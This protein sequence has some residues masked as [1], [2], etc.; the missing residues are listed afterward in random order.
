MQT[1]KNEF[2]KFLRQLNI[3]REIA[4]FPENI[5]RELCEVKRFLEVNIPVKMDNGEVKI[6]KGYRSQYND[7]RG[8]FKGGIRF[9]ENV[10]ESEVKALSAWM[11]F[12]CAVVD[13]PLGG[14]KGG[15]IVDPKKLSGGELERLSRGYIRAISPIIGDRVDIPAPD[16]NTNEKI[17]SFMLDEYEVIRGHHEA[18]VITGKPLSLGGSRARSYATAQGGFYVIDS[19]VKKL[20]IK[21][22]ATVA[23]QGF[24]NAGR[25]AAFILEKAGYKITSVSDSKGV[26]FNKTGLNIAKVAEHKDAKGTVSGYS[27]AKDMTEEERFSEKVDI[28][29]PA[30]LENSVTEERAKALKNTKLIAELANGPITAEA[31]AVFEASGVPV[32][33]DILTNAGGVTVS[34]FEQVQNAFGFYWEEKE[35]L[36]KLE[37]VMR[38]AFEEIWKVSK[39]KKTSLRNAAYI[40]AVS[41]I[42]EAMT[43]RGRG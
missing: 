37:T 11:A 9:H 27:K 7:A 29:I 5:Y 12:K 3:I 21:K 18:G 22:G 40:I 34:Y 1:T 8:P 10:N 20:G 24:G 14:G 19:A 33:P 35:V 16:V 31:A 42:S 13:I 4:P 28:F 17:M 30:A 2:E 23:I 39:V 26:I 15:V 43:A 41:R 25:N 32:L 36:A 6:F 38:S